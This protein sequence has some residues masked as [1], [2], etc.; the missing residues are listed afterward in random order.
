MTTF[1]RL[2]ATTLLVF[3]MLTPG[4]LG[5]NDRTYV[6]DNASVDEFVFQGH[7]AFVLRPRPIAGEAVTSRGWVWFAPVLLRNEVQP[8]NVHNLPIFRE[9]I[10]HNIWVAGVDVGESYGNSDGT[11]LYGRFYNHIVTE[12][13]L[14][15]K[16]CLL[17]QSRGGLMLYNWA[18]ENPKDVSC[19]A[20]IFPVVNIE[21]WP[22][23]TDKEFPAAAAAY[24]LPVDRFRDEIHPHNPIEHLQV[25]ANERVPILTIHG[26]QDKIVSLDGNGK[27][28]TARYKELGGEAELIVVKGKG[29]AEDDEYLKSADVIK[30][31]LHFSKGV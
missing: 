8:P 12:L 20:G 5:A 1:E 2:W 17:A 19:I 31:L 13:R 3:A 24:N 18:I 22:R 16:P 25:L 26:D 14:S 6:P 10:S 23:I 28:L 11:A 15:A 9:L 7:N 29:H 4:S 27:T 30:F 21:T